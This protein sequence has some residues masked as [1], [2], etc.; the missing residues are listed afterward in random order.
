MKYD[1]KRLR[2]A[3]TS[4]GDAVLDPAL[5]PELMGEISGAIAT[6][7]AALIP[8]RSGRT[9]IPVTESVVEAFQRYF[10]LN[11]HLTDVRAIRG[12]PLHLAGQS[13]IIDQDIFSCEREM[14]SNPLYENLTR[15]GLRWWA[16]IGFR[17]GDDIWGMCFQ[18][19][20]KE[21]VFTESDKALLTPLSAYLGEV[22][23]LSAAVGHMA[24]SSATDA[25]AYVEQ[26]AIAIDQTGKVISANR[27]AIESFDEDFYL[28][29]QQII[30]QDN[31]ARRDL[32]DLYERIKSRSD[33]DPLAVSP[34][35]IKRPDNRYLV[36]RVLPVPP[37]AKMPFLGARALLIFSTQ[38][39][40]HLPDPSLLGR[41]FNLTK[42]E[43]RLARELADGQSLGDIAT[44]L[45][46]KKETVRNQIKSIF[47]KTG[48]NRQGQLVALLNQIK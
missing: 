24:I 14:L 25:L 34:I 19:A 30:V 39:K 46:L 20:I 13:V 11:L 28:R 1:L 40:Q 3:A 42:A 10:E 31:Q 21:G 23:S 5:W 18:R 16:A 17:A 27:C 43:V 35:I 44:G 29:N 9:D 12:V 6:T 41:A 48:T 4:L 45:G 32:D 8:G 26:A 2:T 7:G 47:A 22:A 33:L 15:F 38:S 36:L 37:A